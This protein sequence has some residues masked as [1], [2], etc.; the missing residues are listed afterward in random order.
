M[1]D[2]PARLEA[3]CRTAFGGTWDAMPEDEK[4]RWRIQYRQFV[5]AE[6]KAEEDRP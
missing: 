6:I 1:T 2:L 4:A 3:H 5:E